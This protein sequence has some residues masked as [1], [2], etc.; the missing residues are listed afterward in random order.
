MFNPHNGTNMTEQ[1]VQDTVEKLDAEK[2]TPKESMFMQALHDGQVS[3]DI[4]Q[5]YNEF[6]SAGH[7]S[8]EDYTGLGAHLRQNEEMLEIVDTYFK[9]LE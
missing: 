7:K 9:K 4:I 2:M 1:E 3:T 5:E 6:L 8:Y